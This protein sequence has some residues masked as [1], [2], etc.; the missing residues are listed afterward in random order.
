MKSPIYAP[1]EALGRVLKEHA[2]ELEALG[3]ELQ[4]DVRTLAIA[5][6]EGV[7]LSRN[8][9]TPHVEDCRAE[10]LLQKIIQETKEEANNVKLYF[11]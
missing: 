9:H 5:Y 3:N 4:N 10:K 6:A 11:H 8:P 7:A 2:K 1:T